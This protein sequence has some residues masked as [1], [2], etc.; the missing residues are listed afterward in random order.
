MLPRPAPLRTAAIDALAW[1]SSALAG[2]SLAWGALGLAEPHPGARGAGAAV[3]AVAMGALARRRVRARKGGDLGRVVANALGA[4]VGAF[5][6]AGAIGGVCAGAGLAAGAG[7][8][9]AASL[10]YGVA[11]AVVGCIALL[12]VVRA[13]RDARTLQAYDS[14]ERAASTAGLVLLGAGAVPVA[15]GGALPWIAFGCGLSLLGAAA[16]RDAIRARWLARVHAGREPGWAV[17]P[18]EGPP[19]LP[20]VATGIPVAALLTYDPSHGPYRAGRPAPVAATSRDGRAV[21]RWLERRAQLALAGAAVG[22]VVVGA[23]WGAGRARGAHASRVAPPPPAPRCV[24]ARA[25]FR[26]RLGEIAG[27]GRA[28]LLTH[29][30]D[31]AIAE[32]EGVLLLEPRAGGTPSAEQRAQ[33]LAIAQSIPCRDKLALRVEDPVL[34]P[35]DVHAKLTLEEGADRARVRKQAEEAIADVF[36]PT[37]A[38]VVLRHVDFGAEERRVG[39]QIAYV[40]RTTEGVRRATVTLDGRRGDVELAPREFPVLRRLELVDASGAAL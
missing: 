5:V 22:L 38:A 40:L 8:G 39:W 21:S 28:T 30:E 25:Y 32:G 4:A 23:S 14:W 3:F 9:L 36:E 10:V 1:G 16:S 19:A 12:A 29:A 27:I 6:L 15:V 37:D 34:R 7:R 18:A 17:E 33:A 31:G 13:V 20:P 2:A 11:L 24:D 26:E 35:I